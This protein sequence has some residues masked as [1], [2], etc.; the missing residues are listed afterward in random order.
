[1][2]FDKRLQGLRKNK[3]LTQEQLAEKIFVSRAA[4]SKWES[5]RGYPSIDSLKLVAEFF[6]LTLDELI[7]GD[8]VLSIAQEDRKQQK[9]GFRDLLFGLMDCSV[10]IFFFLPFFRQIGEGKVYGVPLVF[11]RGVSVYI[12]LLFIVLIG[13][14]SIWGSLML[15]LQN[16]N[17]KVWVCLKNKISL[18][19]NILGIVLFIIA[20]QPYAAVGL[21]VYLIIKIFLLFKFK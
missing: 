3:G 5:G 15:F 14:I 17:F 19:L 8:E 12:K 16:S 7:S 11:L 18:L 2:S 13:S 10:G 9:I 6:S 4:V 1:M 20:L 21:F